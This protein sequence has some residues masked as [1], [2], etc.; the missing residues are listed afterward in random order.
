[1]AS[2]AWLTN[3][4]WVVTLAYTLN[5]DVATM[6]RWED[7]LGD[8]A[9]ISRVPGRGID[10]TI[11]ADDTT[12]DQALATARASA[13]E[14]IH[15]VDPVGVEIITEDEQLRRGEALTSP[16]LMS[17]AEVAEALKVSR[18]RVHQLRTAE[19][20]PEPLADLR[21]GAVWDAPAIRQFAVECPR[22]PGRPPNP[23]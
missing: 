6:G 1:M 7:Q 4:N 9:T 18:Q 12:L 17:A 11:H 3:R 14:V 15:D 16:E 5:P 21:G 19:S 13:A 8:D 23:G 2:G 10:L 20:F 22:R